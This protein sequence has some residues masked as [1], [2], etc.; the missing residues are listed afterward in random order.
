MRQRSGAEHH[1]VGAR[2]PAGGGGDAVSPARVRRRDAG[3]PASCVDGDRGCAA[4]SGRGEPGGGGVARALRRAPGRG[5]RAQLRRADGALPRGADRRRRLGSAVAQAGRA[6]GR[7]RGGPR[8]DARCAR[9]RGRGARGDR[10]G[11]LEL[12]D[13]RQSQCSAADRRLR[14]DGGDRRGR[15]RRARRGASRSAAGRRGCVS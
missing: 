12:R 13:D 4:R 2:G 10:R 5:D 15:D 3:R 1:R 8:I 9:D 6:D 11:R 7:R 14:P